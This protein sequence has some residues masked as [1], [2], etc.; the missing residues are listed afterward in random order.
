MLYQWTAP[1]VIEDAAYRARFSR[2]PTPV[3]RI[4]RD[5]VAWARGAFKL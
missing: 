5:T 3:D 1:F 2:A 4:V